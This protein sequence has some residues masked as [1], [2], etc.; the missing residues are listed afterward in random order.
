MAKFY[1]TIG[2]VETIETSPGVCVE[3]AH[4]RNYYGDILQNSRRYD[5]SEQLNDD[6]NVS[7]RFSIMADAYAYDHFFAMRYIKWM[8]ANWKIHYVEVN[9]PR[10]TIT[11]GGLYNGKT[12]GTSE[13]S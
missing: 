3:E 7:N 12:P 6:L 11:V 2:F 1:G 13:D 10:L 8:G 9:R 4:E 5:V